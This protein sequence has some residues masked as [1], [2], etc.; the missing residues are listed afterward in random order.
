[1]PFADTDLDAMLAAT[2]EPV[3]ILLSGVTVSTITGKFRKNY[4]DVSPYESH[5]GILKSVFL[6]KTSDLAGITND[7][8]FNIQGVDYRFDGK[9]EDEPTGL[10]K[11]KLGIKK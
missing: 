9:P 1:M 2:G 8:Y 3:V 4:V 10:T 6:C 7:H 5:V 11:V